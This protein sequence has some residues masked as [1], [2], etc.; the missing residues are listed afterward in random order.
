MQM[1]FEI[2]HLILWRW[3]GK[4][5]ICVAFNRRGKTNLRGICALV[6]GTV[7][8]STGHEASEGENRYSSTLSLTSALDRGG[9]LTPRPGP[10]TPGKET[11]CLLNRRLGGP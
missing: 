1:C 3:G 8:P 11:R 9:W 6:Q 7:R 2:K 5:E 4:I 10:F